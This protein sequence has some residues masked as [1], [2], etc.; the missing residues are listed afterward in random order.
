AIPHASPDEGVHEVSMSLLKLD[1]GVHFA[2]QYCIHVLV[3]IAAVDKHR[4]LKALMQLMKLAGSEEDVRHILQAASAE[5][6]RSILKKY[7][8]E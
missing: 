3:V 7:A 8:T 2:G 1:R 6:I 5:E 4:H